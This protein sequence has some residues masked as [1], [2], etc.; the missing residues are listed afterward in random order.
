MQHPS[1]AEQRAVPARQ[2]QNTEE[3][4]PS[5]DLVPPFRRLCAGGRCA[6]KTLCRVE[7]L[8]L[9]VL[10][11]AVDKR[12]FMENV[13][14]TGTSNCIADWDLKLQLRPCAPFVHQKCSYRFNDKFFY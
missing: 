3:H 1:G 9:Q 6:H 5:R 10:V 4:G 8:G 7:C 11:C 14:P 2:C 12:L 13:L